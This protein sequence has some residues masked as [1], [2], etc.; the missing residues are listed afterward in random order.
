[1]KRV[2]ALAALAAMLLSGCGSETAGPAQNTKAPETTQ[3]TP[4]PSPTAK[5]AQA[6]N[7]GLKDKA[8]ELLADTYAAD[9]IVSVSAAN[10]RLSVKIADGGIGSMSEAP[11]NWGDITT[12]AET[13]CTVLLDGWGTDDY[14]TVTIQMVDSEDNILLTVVNGR[15]S[16]SKFAAPADY[17]E[18]APT[19]S[20]EEFNAI[21]MGMTYDEVFKIVGS[22]GEEVSRIDIGAGDEYISV[23]FSWEGEGSF[24]ASAS[25]I[26]DGG[27]AASKVQFGLE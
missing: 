3:A 2:I 5:A 7:D 23:T 12:T 10:K 6:D 16:Y 15:V 25:V 26:F 11:E 24:G 27:K 8:V 18:N 20:L 19:I 21:Q 17:T 1:M 14:N 13:A 4:L 9:D 22:R